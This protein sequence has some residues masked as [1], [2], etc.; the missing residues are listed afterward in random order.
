M[1][2]YL[3]GLRGNHE[4]M[5]EEKALRTLFFEKSVKKRRSSQACGMNNVCKC[6]E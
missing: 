4:K 5:S 1:T 3:A 2:C 6:W